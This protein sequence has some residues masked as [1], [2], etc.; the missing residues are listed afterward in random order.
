MKIAMIVA[1]ATASLGR[2]AAAQ[3]Q[4][5]ALQPTADAS[6]YEVRGETE[7][8][9]G[10]G[11]SVF[12]GMTGG[13]SVRRALLRF[14]VATH[15]PAGST[16]V[17]ASLR[18]QL[19]NTISGPQLVRLHRV[20]T[21]WTEGPTAPGGG[22][23]GGA[24]AV[25]GDATWS[26]ASLPGAAWT[27]L[28]GDFVAASSATKSVDQ[29]GAYEW[30][31]PGLDADVQGWVDG[32]VDHGWIVLGNE[33]EIASAKR[34][35]SRENVDPDARP[36]LTIDFVPPPG[37]P[38]DWDGDGDTDSDDVVLFFGA[39]DNGEGDVDGDE[40]SDSDDIVAFFGSW[41]SGC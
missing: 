1:A 24:P 11:Q 28:G 12:C 31:G 18:M 41:D 9:N 8:A 25:A 4:T 29:L 21:A 35:A 14:D 16:V 34:F 38:G 26:F 30:S 23:G 5:V 36:V 13:A 22:E 40:D 10:A 39:W 15:V 2:V 17:G 20:T 32:V 3:V 19:T 6:L 7:N 27:N 37:C 33:G